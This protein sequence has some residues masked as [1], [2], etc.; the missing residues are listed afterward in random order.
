[1]TSN[2]T[3]RS[4]QDQGGQVARAIAVLEAVAEHGSNTPLGG[5]PR[6]PRSRCPRC[7]GSRRS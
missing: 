3:G 2:D 7:T 6:R 5:S 1:M 4:A